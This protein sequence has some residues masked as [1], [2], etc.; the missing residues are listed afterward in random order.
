MSWYS[1]GTVA[2]ANGAVTV[3][4]SGTAW[5][6]A[7]QTG[8]GFIGPDGRAYEIDSINDDTS[9]TLSVNY[10]GST[11]AA[12]TYSC[13]PTM[14]LAS[15]LADSFQSLVTQF[16]GIIDGIGAGKFPDGT[17]GDLALRFA[18]DPDTGFYRPGS[19]KIGAVTGGTLR[20]QVSSSAMQIDVPITGDAVQSGAEDATAGKVMLT[21]AFGLGA[22]DTISNITDIDATDTP[23]GDWRFIP[24]TTNN[25]SL[26]SAMQGEFGVLSLRRYNSTVFTQTVRKT[27]LTGGEW[28]RKYSSSVWGDWE[29]IWD[30]TTLPLVSSEF[31]LVLEDESSNAVTQGTKMI[32]YTRVGPQ[33][34]YYF[35]FGDVQNLT[36]LVGADLL[37]VPLP[38]VSSDRSF[39]TVG[40]KSLVS[41]TG[42]YA[43]HTKP[44]ESY[45]YIYD[46]GA[47]ANMTVNQFDATSEF[48][49]NTLTV[50]VA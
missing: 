12:Q 25:A 8:W 20:W 45:A 18:A 7:L 38:L 3:T 19:N 27:D 6:A 1:T 17:A 5:F 31:A 26:P 34:S 42:P 47:G 24:A 48:I 14:S 35:G 13:W 39:V 36:G 40:L 2:V 15:D 46:L 9:L 21:G 44:G 37:R 30:S 29:Q 28:R 33:A 23:S 4:G 50:R 43:W 10:Q 32:P 41:G 49:G 11:A 16:Q 22:T